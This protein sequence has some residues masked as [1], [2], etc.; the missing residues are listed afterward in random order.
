MNPIDIGDSTIP[1]GNSVMLLNMVRIGKLDEAKIFHENEALE[2]S[3]HFGI[4]NF[5]NT[6][7]AI[8]NRIN[9][10]YCKK[11]I[12][13]LPNQNHPTHRHIQKEECFELLHGDCTVTLGSKVIRL[14]KGKPLLVPRRVNHSFKSELG[15]VI[16][17]V[18]TTHIKG[19]S[20]YDDPNI[21]KLPLESR[22]IITKLCP[23]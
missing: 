7:C 18:S 6:G 10:E 21:N 2:I 13:V 9:R 17:E 15:C 5:H 1:N 8:I 4:S 22:K 20:I 14:Q 12:V 16:E 11:L 23:N 3:C 19:D